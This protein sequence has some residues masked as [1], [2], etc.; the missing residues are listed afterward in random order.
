MLH[1]GTPD[2]VITAEYYAD[3]SEENAWAVATWFQHVALEDVPDGADSYDEI[4]GFAAPGGTKWI[5]TN[6]RST[7][8]QQLIGHEITKDR[9]VELVNGV[10]GQAVHEVGGE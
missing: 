9:Y 1:E 8:D 4:D 7:T 5:V 3:D 6:R 10:V 2:A